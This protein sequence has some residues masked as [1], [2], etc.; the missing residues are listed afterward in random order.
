MLLPFIRERRSTSIL[1]ETPPHQLLSLKALSRFLTKPYCKVFLN[2]ESRINGYISCTKQAQSTWSF[3][4]NILNLICKMTVMKQ[5]LLKSST[6]KSGGE[7][8]ET[9][10]WTRES[11]MRWSPFTNLSAHDQNSIVEKCRRCNWPQSGTVNLKNLLTNLPTNIETEIKQIFFLRLLN[12][13]SSITLS[14]HITHMLLNYT[15]FVSISCMSSKV[16]RRNL[17]RNC[18]NMRSQWCM[19]RTQ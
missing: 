15:L 11:L 18:V 13:V 12:N 17:R 3:I 4:I 9:G 6:A 8:E 19:R 1:T 16:G 14:I 10:R 2:L 5:N 7:E